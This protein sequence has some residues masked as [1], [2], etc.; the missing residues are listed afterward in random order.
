MLVL[1]G[2]MY[3]IVLRAAGHNALTTELMAWIVGELEIAAGQPVLISG[4]G[5]V[6]S[7]GLNLKEIATLD[8]SGMERFLGQLEEMVDALY[9]YPG[10]T[11]A[12]VNGHAI[13]GGCVI[14][15]ACDLRVAAADPEVRIGLNEVAL[16]LRFPPKTFAMVRQ[17]VP[18]GSLERVILEAG[19]YAPEQART[20]GLVDEVAFDPLAVARTRLSRLAAHPRDAYARTKEELRAG[21]LDVTEAAKARY[22]REVLPVWCSDETRTRVLA[23]LKK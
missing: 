6:F 12:C 16:G 23:V 3:E 21:V 11:V 17:R 1:G 13:A 15:L 18:P 9:T 4:A 20:L 8:E 10:P 7:A 22:L 5:S 19:L 14:A 2:A